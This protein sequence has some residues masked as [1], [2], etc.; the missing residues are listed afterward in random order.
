VAAGAKGNPAK[1]LV[2]KFK[3]ILRGQ[4][5]QDRTGNQNL[6]TKP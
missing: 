2:G 5:V 3:E 4:I 6:K 1:V